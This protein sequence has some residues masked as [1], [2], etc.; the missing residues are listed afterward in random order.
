VVI[1][2]DGPGGVGKSTVTRAVALALGIDF[3]DTGSTYRAATLAVLRAGVDS[4]D[5]DAVIEVVSAADITYRRGEVHLDG[6]SVHQAVRSHEVT[7]AVSAV[8]AIPEVRERIVAI[9]RRWV[10]GRGSN[11]VVEGRDIGS[12][13]FPD[14]EV[15]V[16][17]TARPE[18]RAARRSG[19]AEAQ[20]RGVADIRRELERRDHVDANRPVAPMQAAPDA[21][22]IDTSELPISEVVDRILE[23][24]R[25]VD[26]SAAHGRVTS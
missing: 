11:A 6:V 13:V 8:S 3:L 20:G 16:F 25:R 24:V 12:V 23:L 2:I 17:L 9:Q 15:K 18:V 5:E 19:D 1:A 14:A 7:A 21:V 26:P 22:T 4:D 10:E